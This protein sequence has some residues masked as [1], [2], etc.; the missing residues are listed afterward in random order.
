M[1]TKL[2][3]NLSALISDPALIGSDRELSVII[4]LTVLAGPKEQDALAASG[5]TTRSMIGDIVTGTVAPGNLAKLVQIPWVIKVESS[6]PLGI[7]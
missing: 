3:P 5:V 2:D 1:S 6:T 4:A 7:G